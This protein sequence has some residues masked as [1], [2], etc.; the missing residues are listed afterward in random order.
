[1]YQLYPAIASQIGVS[2]PRTSGSN[3]RLTISHVCGI[4]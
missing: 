3:S 2:L 4:A 1:V